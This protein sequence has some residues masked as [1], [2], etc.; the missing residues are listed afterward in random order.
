MDLGG[1]HGLAHKLIA[2]ID[3][4]RGRVLEVIPDNDF[5]LAAIQL[6]VVIPLAQE[7]DAAPPY[8]AH[9][10]AHHK[11]SETVTIHPIALPR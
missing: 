4:D 8:G 3:Q 9:L 2:L 7:L 11:I 6:R 1:D 10:L 5:M